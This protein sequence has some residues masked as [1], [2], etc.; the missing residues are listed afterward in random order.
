VAGDPF[1]EGLER[2]LPGFWFPKDI[3]LGDIIT[4]S[5][6]GVE[7]DCKV[8]GIF[9]HAGSGD[10][11]YKTSIRVKVL[12]VEPEVVIPVLLA[13]TNDGAG[14]VW[15]SV[16][17]GEVWDQAFD[18]GG[19]CLSLCQA[20]N[21]DAIAGEW[22]GGGAFWVS[23]D[24]GISFTEEDSAG[25]SRVHC[26][27]RLEND[28]LLAGIGTN[29]VVSRSKDDGQTW[30]NLIDFG[31][32]NVNSLVQTASGAVLAGTNNDADVWRSEDDGDNWAQVY[33]WATETTIPAMAL[34]ESGR[35][36]AAVYGGANRGIYVS[37]DDGD[38]WTQKQN[39]AT[40]FRSLTLLE[41][42]HM[43]AGDTNGW[44]W[45]S[46]DNA[47]TWVQNVQL[48]AATWIWSLLTL[49]NGDVL[50][51]LYQKSHIY[52]STD[53]GATWTKTTTPVAGWNVY[54]LAELVI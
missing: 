1:R 43:L 11:S 53:N 54:A 45:R 26:I 23:K 3:G 29:S 20:A 28:W 50:A 44:T 52:K 31:D 40:T 51:G 12:D 17:G 6:A 47:E 36:V 21:G 24:G 37:D 34:T 35:I 39:G 49:D 42:G 32:T 14:T 30:E 27:I 22:G 46:T 13:G 8:T 15:R 9:L 25:E 10:A 33:N 4:V 7:A 19:S 16:D 38:N 2:T 5:Y 41:S 18:L 48:D